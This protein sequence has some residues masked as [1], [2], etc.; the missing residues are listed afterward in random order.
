MAVT[1]NGSR[2]S[3]RV[4]A[5]E[6]SKPRESKQRKLKKTMSVAVEAEKKKKKKQPA[7]PRSQHSHPPYFQM[8]VEAIASLRE[9]TGSSHRAIA[10]YIEAHYKG[11]LPSNFKKLLTNQ[12]RILAEKGK[13]VQVKRSFKLTEELKKSSQVKAVKA[14]S[15]PPA[16]GNPPAAKKPKPVGQVKAKNV[17]TKSPKPK[18]AK[19]NEGEARR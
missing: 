8:A 11:E 17:S 15:K 6:A 2:K 14:A 5:K 16:S 9:R 10:K 1:A 12:L 7:G 13:L 4:A 19:K 18:A 3:S